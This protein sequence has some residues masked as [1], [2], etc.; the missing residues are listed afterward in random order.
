MRVS[1]LNKNYGMNSWWVN[2][3]EQDRPLELMQAELAQYGATYG[4]PYQYLE[5]SSED[6][7]AWFLLRWG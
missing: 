6:N 7:Y 2:F 1:L 5:F 4:P 3:S